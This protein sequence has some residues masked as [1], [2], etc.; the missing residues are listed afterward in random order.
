MN[1]LFQ[2]YNKI[3]PTEGGT[4]RTTITVATA[5]KTKYGC[6]CYAIY[7]RADSSAM[8][9]CLDGEYHWEVVRDEAQNAAT[10]RQVIEQWHIDAIIV[11]GA[12]IHVKR[13]RLAIQGINCHLIFAHHFAPKWEI[14]FFRINTILKRRPHSLRS[15]CRWIY[16]VILFP[17]ARKQ[18]IQRL[19]LQYCEAYHNADNVVLLSN[20]FIRPYQEFGGFQDTD[21]FRI[22]PNGLSLTEFF[23]CE[24]LNEKKNIV[25]IVSRL[26]DPPKK[27]S[28][29]LEIW[30][31][32]RAHAESNGWEL[33]I[34]GEGP[35]ADKLYSMVK[36]KHIPD[37][38][39]WGRQ[40]PNTYYRQAS[41]FMMTSKSESWGLTLTEAQQM[42]VV[43]IAFDTYPSLHDI[44]TDGF[45][46]V[47]VAKDDIDGY[48][49]NVLSLMTDVDRRRRLAKNGLTSCLR[50]IPDT[51]VEQWWHLINNE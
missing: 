39:F 14:I 38:K 8:V 27:I 19:S 12:F 33:Q 24:R 51:I 25:L 5:L 6:R 49:D 32:V 31:R 41:I 11:Q 18:Y 28:V 21:K 46:G 9:D 43:P 13:F 48:V 7:E 17:Y 47:I 16:N 44:I 42:G 36:Q 10:L 1:V 3:H 40:V 30:R 26:D 45:D 50:F 23:P 35:D 2:T 20:K 22:I 29:A 15:T 4:E 37:V 34:V